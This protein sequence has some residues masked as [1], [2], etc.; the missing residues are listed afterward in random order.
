MLK[1]I[2]RYFIGTICLLI[3]IVSLLPSAAYPQ[4]RL[5]F[6]TLDLPR[7]QNELFIMVKELNPAHYN[8]REEDI[9]HVVAI[10]SYHIMSLL[11]NTAT[12]IFLSVT[13]RYISDEARKITKEYKFLNYANSMDDLAINPTIDKNIGLVTALENSIS[14]ENVRNPHLLNTVNRIKFKTQEIIKELQKYSR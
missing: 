9:A 10:R 8:T 13:A 2:S 14:S 11:E 5:G 4:N 7:M 12:L 3:L 1:A 6:A